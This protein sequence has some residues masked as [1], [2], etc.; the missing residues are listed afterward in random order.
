ML[1]Q[2]RVEA[3]KAYYA[4]FLETAPDVFALAALPEDRLLKLWEGLGYYNRARN[5]Q[6][7]A[8]RIVSRGGTFPNTKAELQKLPP[9]KIYEKQEIT[10][11]DILKTSKRDFKIRVEGDVFIV[12]APWLAKILM[13]T[14]LND[15]SSLQ[16]FQNVLQTSGIIQGL[17]RQALVQRL[18]HFF[19]KLR[20]RVTA[21]DQSD[22]LRRVIADPYCSRILSGK[23]AVPTVLG[24]G[25]SAGLAGSGN[26]QRTAQISL[27]T[28]TDNSAVT[29]L[30]NSVYSVTVVFI[31]NAVGSCVTEIL[32]EFRPRI[33][34][35]IKRIILIAYLF[36]VLTGSSSV[37]GI[38]D[39]NGVTLYG[40]G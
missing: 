21:I 30:K 10:P 22:N 27:F 29:V 3:V 36:K 6:K 16:Y 12:E 9:V 25:G 19:P 7:C 4:R 20:S 14:N 32:H 5:L 26:A 40:N 38:G 37:R 33:G 15:Y 18:H 11:K 2:T 17:I 1:Q 34:Y 13:K 8:S 31:S 24:A 39:N 35:V 23:T 28:G